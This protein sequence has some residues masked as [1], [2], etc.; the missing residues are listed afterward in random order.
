MRLLTTPEVAK[1]LGITVSRVQALINDH[2]LPAQKIGRDFMVREDD[3][4]LVSS[5]QVGRTPAQLQLDYWTAFR[6][7]VL[8]QSSL[9][10]PPPARAQRTM[11]LKTMRGCRLAASLHVKD[12]QIWVDLTFDRD[13]KKYFQRL[14]KNHDFI[15]EQIGFEL[16]WVAR[17]E[18]VESWI[19]VREPADP[20]VRDDW[21]RQHSWLCEKLEQ[22][23]TVLLP[24]LASL[25]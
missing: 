23:S 3:L 13:S 7:F 21:A 22:F 6:N 2:R 14:E 20:A 24:K 17:P 8:V 9:L 15:E 19:L 11:I 10:K 25:R 4:V 12:R 1:R 5:R 16:E 18:G